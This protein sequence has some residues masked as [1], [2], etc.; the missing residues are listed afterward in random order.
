MVE[1]LWSVYNFLISYVIT[2]AVCFIVGCIAF[3]KL[4]VFKK[5][6]NEKGA[7]NTANIAVDII[8]K[9]A[10]MLAPILPQ[11]ASDIADKVIS[12]AKTSVDGAEQKYNAGLIPKEQRKPE[13]T[14]FVSSAL[15]MS[16]YTVTPEVQAAIDLAVEAA[17][18]EAKDSKETSFTDTVTTVSTKTVS[19]GAVEGEESGTI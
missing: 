5:W 19:N 9:L 15:T 14:N 3:Y 18:K 17:V 10:D 12:Y 4:S 2:G 8:D 7:I 16:G 11:A 1:W 13:A 6:K